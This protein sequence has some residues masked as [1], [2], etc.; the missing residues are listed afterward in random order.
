MDLENVW[1]LYCDVCVQNVGRPLFGARDELVNYVWL[2]FKFSQTYV[3]NKFTL[4]FASIS[5]V[6][7]HNFHGR[8]LYEFQRSKP[9]S[10][11]HLLYL[12]PLSKQ[13][14]PNYGQNTRRG[15]I[16]ISRSILDSP[17]ASKQVHSIHLRILFHTISWRRNFFSHVNTLRN[18][19]Y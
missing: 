6:N 8:N 10:K 19:I 15:S 17:T 11:L 12:Y 7:L 18:F 3:N 1:R 13:S 9:F 4:R 16:R 2:T 5:G 14:F